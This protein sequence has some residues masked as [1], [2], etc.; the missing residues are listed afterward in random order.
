MFKCY[1][2]RIS[3]MTAVQ[4]FCPSLATN[5]MLVVVRII[6]NYNCHYNALNTPSA[7]LQRTTLC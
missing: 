6:F 4:Q 3:N 5:D 7:F 2:T 1:T